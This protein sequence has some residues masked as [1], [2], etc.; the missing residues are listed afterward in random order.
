MRI[1]VATR[2]LFGLFSHA[3]CRHNGEIDVTG[4]RDK[5]SGKGGD[6]WGWRRNFR[7]G[8]NGIA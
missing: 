8:I 3:K 2:A 5:L 6:D 7:R 4:R 1:A